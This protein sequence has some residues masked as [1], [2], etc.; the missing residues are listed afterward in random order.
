MSYCLMKFLLLSTEAEEGGVLGVAAAEANGKAPS[1][2]EGE[3]LLLLELMETLPRH[4]MARRR[5]VATIIS[6]KLECV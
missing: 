3:L 2:E 1:D 4:G 6:C 5:G